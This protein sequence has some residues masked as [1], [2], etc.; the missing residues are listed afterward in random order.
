MRAPIHF[1]FTSGGEALP[2]YQS[3]LDAAAM[4]YNLNLAEQRRRA[5]LRRVQEE[6]KQNRKGDLSDSGQQKEEEQKQ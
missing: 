1:S 3:I 5:A 6:F 4:N 2:L